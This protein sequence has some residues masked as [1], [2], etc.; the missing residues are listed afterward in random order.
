MHQGVREIETHTQRRDMQ[1]ER[2]SDLTVAE[3][4]REGPCIRSRGR[5]RERGEPSTSVCDTERDRE[6]TQSKKGVG[7]VRER[8]YARDK[9]KEKDKANLIYNKS[10]YTSKREID[11]ERAV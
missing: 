3:G 8:K 11:P 10:V 5:E 2:E 6:E 7:R 9:D 4:E 1:S